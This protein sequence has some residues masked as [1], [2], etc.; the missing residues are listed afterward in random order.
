[1]YVKFLASL[2]SRVPSDTS[3]RGLSH[4]PSHNTK[5]SSH[6]AVPAVCF[7][8]TPVPVALLQIAELTATVTSPAPCTHLM[9]EHSP[10]QLVFNIFEVR[11]ATVLTLL[12]RHG[13]TPRSGRSR[14]RASYCAG[15]RHSFLILRQAV[16]IVTTV[17][18]SNTRRPKK[19]HVASNPTHRH[20]LQ[21]EQN[22]I[23]HTHTQIMLSP[24]SCTIPLTFYRTSLFILSIRRLA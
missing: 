17:V 24:G 2:F 1:M 16:N 13:V 15:C 9:F 19:E 5:H 3:S 12:W 18:K 8:H 7:P 23:S 14:L 21:Q 20:R 10:T 6:S 22:N 4:S 11:P